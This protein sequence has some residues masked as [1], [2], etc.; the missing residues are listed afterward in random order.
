M[1]VADIVKVLVDG[2]AD[3]D[4]ADLRANLLGDDDGVGL[5]AGEVP[6]QGR[7]QAM[8]FVLGSPIFFTAMALTMTARVESTPPEMPT[9][10]WSSPAYSMRFTRPET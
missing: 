3:V 6:K 9:T 10:Q 5:G 1:R 4:N 8:T 2:L 7:V